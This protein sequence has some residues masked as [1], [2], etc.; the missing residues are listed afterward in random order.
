[1]KDKCQKLDGRLVLCISKAIVI[2]VNRNF[3]KRA[4]ENKTNNPDK[5]G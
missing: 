2:K 1:L 5:N 3:K 4:F